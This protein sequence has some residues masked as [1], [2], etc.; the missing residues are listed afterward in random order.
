MPQSRVCRKLRHS[1]FRDARLSVVG[2]ESTENGEA[3]L[4]CLEQARQIQL[5]NKLVMV[6]IAPEIAAE[7][8]CCRLKK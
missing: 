4:I 5:G 6:R 7:A 1:E 3:Y 8:L 2:P